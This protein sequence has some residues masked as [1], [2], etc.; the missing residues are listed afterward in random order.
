MQIQL[1]TQ[2]SSK[3]LV[4]PETIAKLSQ[5]KDFYNIYAPNPLI[6]KHSRKPEIRK[7]AEKAGTIRTFDVN[8]VLQKLF[9]GKTA[10]VARSKELESIES[11]FNKDKFIILDERY[12]LSQF[13]FFVSK[14]FRYWRESVVM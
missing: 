6:L 10:L 8:A 12:F 11:L 9:D 1:L 4:W 7:L 3:G 13:A 14:K 2:L 5:K